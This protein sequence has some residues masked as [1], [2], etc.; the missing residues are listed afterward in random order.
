MTPEQWDT[1]ARAIKDSNFFT[2]VPRRIRDLEREDYEIYKKFFPKPV[3]EPE[4]EP[5]PELDILT[6]SD[7]E[8]YALYGVTIGDIE[9]FRE[10]YGCVPEFI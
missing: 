1:I 5:E 9:N 2:P 7:E 6:C 4:P 3:P 10:R 8:F